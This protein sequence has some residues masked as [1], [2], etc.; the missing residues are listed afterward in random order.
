MPPTED[1]PVAEDAD[2]DESEGGVEGEGADENRGEDETCGCKVGRLVATY[3]L[4]GVDEALVSRWTGPGETESV[5]S[6]T[7]WLNRQA[8]R[9][10]LEP[11]DIDV[12][13]GRVENLYRLLTDSDVLVA[14]RMET[15]Q[16]LAKG[17]IDVEALESRFVSHQTVYRHLRS[18]MDV[19]HEGARAT[20]GSEADRINALQ[21][22]TEAVIA[23]SLER[24]RDREA[25]DLDEFEVLVNFRVMCENCG[26]MR[27]VAT[28]LDEGG[29]ECGPG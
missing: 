3:D 25:V 27:N 26:A 5:R 23:D 9:A 17:G 11:S 12:V 24:L 6:L 7:D 14:V 20:I 21:N 29:C 28:L 8:L 2:A 19:E 22:R 18:C 16:S 1:D 15:E 10:E 4:D 13:E